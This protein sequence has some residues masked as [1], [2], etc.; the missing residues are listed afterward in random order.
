MELFQASQQWATRPADQRFWTLA[1]LHDATHHYAQQAVERKDVAWSTLRTEAD[2]G[3]VCIVGKGNIPA[4]LTH[5]AFGQLSAKVGA[6][7]GYL[8]QLPATLASQNLNHGLKLRGDQ[9]GND[10]SLLFHSNGAYVLRAV[11]SDQY[12]RIW[13]HEVAERLL[14][15]EG[16]GWR[17]PPGWSAEEGDPQA[18]RAVLA[19]V[20]PGGIVKV[21]DMIRPTGL[22]A[23]DHDMFV[24]LVNEDA[25]IMDG[26]PNGLARGVFVSNSEVGA[27]KLRITKFLY[28]YVC[29]NN[30]VWGAKDVQ[31]VAVKHVGDIRGRSAQMFELAMTAYANESVSDVE[32]QIKTARTKRIAATK[33]SLLDYLFGK[34][35]G[36]RKLL[37]DA[38]EAVQ[39]GTDGDPLTYW[40]FVQ[41][42]TRVSQATPFVDERV[43]A[44]KTAAKVLEM[45]F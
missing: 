36:S 31:E 35:V 8:R 30:I 25:R 40:G 10:A 2:A 18:R 7:A 3:E 9:L 13:N 14:D 27:A 21:G 42:A 24:F 15:T 34:R 37:N 45:A 16:T 11:T 23:S 26:T 32:A 28:R 20:I 38:Y 19:D 5:W 33:E 22:Y 39:P 6:P 29:G 12:S 17:T 41:G 4:K 43:E 1:E 44:D